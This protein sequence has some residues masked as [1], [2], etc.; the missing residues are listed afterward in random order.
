MTQKDLIQPKDIAKYFLLRA[1]EDGELISPLKMQKMVYFAYVAYLLQNKGKKKLFDEK[2]EAWPNG[3]VVPSLYLELKKYGSSPI[4]I[5]DY[6]DVSEEYF[7]KKYPQ[8][9]LENLN[10]VYKQC[11]A[12]TAFELT[13]LTHQQKA[14]L[15]AR[16]G[17]APNEPSHNPI[18]DSHIL[19]QHMV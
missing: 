9:V 18:L 14:W 12:Y 1:R 15:E 13:G 16:K 5:E 10:E 7:T 11:S 2:I 6:V 4:K 17:L 3:P 8:E 19:E